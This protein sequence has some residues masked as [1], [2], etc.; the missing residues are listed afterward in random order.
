MERRSKKEIEKG[1]EDKFMAVGI[2]E[3]PKKSGKKDKPLRSGRKPK[4]PS[5]KTKKTPILG[6]GSK[7][8]TLK[9][10]L[11]NPPEE[12]LDEFYARIGLETSEQRKEKDEERKKIIERTG[13]GPPKVYKTPETDINKILVDAVNPRN[14]DSPLRAPKKR[15]TPHEKEMEALSR[16]IGKM[17]DEVAEMEHWQKQEDERRLKEAIKKREWEGKVKQF[18]RY[19][20]PI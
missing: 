7:K 13:T 6:G 16:E 1:R 18:K 15:K 5:P 17:Q 2:E 12:S 14:P 3:K 10:K 9:N 19:G 8:G 4:K 11:A 20:W